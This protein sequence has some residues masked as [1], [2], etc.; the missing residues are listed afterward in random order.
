MLPSIPFP[1]C[2]QQ[3]SQR[4]SKIAVTLKCSGT[5]PHRGPPCAASLRAQALPAQ[6]WAGR[7]LSQPGVAQ[8]GCGCDGMWQWWDVAV[9]FADACGERMQR[10]AGLQ[11]ELSG[12]SLT[13]L[14]GSRCWSSLPGKTERAEQKAWPCEWR[15]VELGRMR[16]CQGSSICCD[17]QSFSLWTFSEPF[18]FP[19]GSVKCCCCWVVYLLHFNCM[20]NR[21]EAAKEKHTPEKLLAITSLH[22]WR[23]FI[24]S[25]LQ[26][27]ERNAQIWCDFLPFYNLAWHFFLGIFSAQLRYK[28]GHVWG[29]IT[30]RKLVGGW[31]HFRAGMKIRSSEMVLRKAFA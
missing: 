2:V 19:A 15:M 18:G 5:K 28:Q 22:A 8:M 6:G 23:G 31:L 3:K 10:W 26:K 13:E 12:V 7:A 30:L 16:W 20:V 17:W 9:G 21:E 29:Y 24:D 27:A 14:P 25:L 1:L 11:P 4:S